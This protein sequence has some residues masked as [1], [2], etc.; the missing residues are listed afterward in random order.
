MTFK[1]TVLVK[2]FVEWLPI[3]IWTSPL[4]FATYFKGSLFDFGP[5]TAWLSEE[6]IPY[7]HASNA[8]SGYAL[9]ET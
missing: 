5:T 8:V 6:I 7:C 3:V 1:L 9:N 4:A 2:W